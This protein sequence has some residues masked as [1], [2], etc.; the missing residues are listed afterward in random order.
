M[1][2]TSIETFFT[3][4]RWMF[5]KVSTDEGICGYGECITIGGRGITIAGAIEE[6]KELLVGQSPLNIENIYQNL[7][8]RTF[9]RGGSV[10]MVAISGIEQALWDIKGKYY[11]LPVYELLGGKVRDKIRLYRHCSYSTIEGS[12][13]IALRAK[14]E[15]FT[16]V[17]YTPEIP[18]EILETKK[19]IKESVDKFRI[20]REALGDEFD[21]AVDFH[22]RFSPAMA[23]RLIEA[24]EPYYPMFI[25]E[26]CLPENIDAM[27]SIADKT[28]IP[29]A[30]GERLSTI[31]PFKDLLQKGGASI[32]QPDICHAGGIWECKKISVLAEAHY[33]SFAPHNPIGPVSLASSMHLN[34]TVP[35][36]LIQEYQGLREEWDIGKEFFKDPLKVENG[37]LIVSDK[38]GLGFE[39][40]EEVFTKY[41]HGGTRTIPYLTRNDGSLADW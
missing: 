11:N 10:F 40:N 7:Y 41:K 8:R 21:I 35:N 32:I 16:A 20:L 18:K 38:P 34:A 6:M 27:A 9:F 37:Y 15:G 33:A 5:V 28:S 39:F 4:P 26:P 3:E 36:F 23:N 24:Y 30:T 2:I 19:F 31:Y 13:E 22:G 17:K 1:K 12:L 14:E 25:E 29:I